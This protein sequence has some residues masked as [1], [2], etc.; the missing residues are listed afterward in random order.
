ME[1]L[2]K[3]LKANENFADN[4][5][6]NILRAFDTLPNFLFTTS[7]ALKDFKFGPRHYLER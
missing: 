3:T 6:H 1:P 2:I 7:E 4:H 5:G